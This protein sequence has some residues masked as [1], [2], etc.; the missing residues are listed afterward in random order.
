MESKSEKLSPS[1]QRV[2]EA[3][4]GR[5]VQLKVVELPESTRTAK[6]AAQAVGCEVGQIAKSLIFRSEP[7]GD[8][9]LVIASGVNRVDEHLVGDYVGEE[10]VIANADYVHEVTGFAIG[11]VPPVGHSSNMKTIVDEDLMRF[12]EIWAAAGT[13]NAVFK[14]TSEMLTEITG[15]IVLKIA[16]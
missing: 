9:V 10:V 11:G 2:Q 6:E 8:P 13:P 14:L 12:E 5:G 7:S 16:I 3:L 15:G 1:A 4:H